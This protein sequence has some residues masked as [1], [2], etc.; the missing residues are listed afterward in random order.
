[1]QACADLSTGSEQP[2]PV[3]VEGPRFEQLYQEHVDFV[4]R[5]L[6]RLGVPERALADVAQEVFIVVHRRLP[7]FERRCSVKTWVFAIAHR[8]V[9]DWARRARRKPITTLEHEVVDVSRSG[10]YE[11]T[12][13]RQAV[14]RL[15]RLLETLSP[16]KRAVFV[17]AELEQMTLAEIAEAVA[18]NPHTVASRLKAARRE[19]EQALRR[20]SLRSAGREP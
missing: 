10:P 4:W 16:E 3:A 2:R 7:T 18:A 19:F 13:K 1:M 12:E 6:A 15:Y 20:E 11:Q 8:V 5:S 9:I 17:L 14:A